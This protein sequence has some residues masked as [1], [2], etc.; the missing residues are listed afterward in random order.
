M[1]KLTQSLLQ[2]VKSDWL[3]LLMLRFVKQCTSYTLSDWMSSISSLNT[4]TL[5]SFQFVLEYRDMDDVMKTW[6]N[7]GYFIKQIE[8]SFCVCTVVGTFMMLFQPEKLHVHQN[9]WLYLMFSLSIFP[10]EMRVRDTQAIIYLLNIM[11]SSNQGNTSNNTELRGTSKFLWK[12]LTIVIKT[13]FWYDF[14]ITFFSYQKS[15]NCVNRNKVPIVGK[16]K[17]IWE[18]NSLKILK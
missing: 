18:K 6:K 2:V 9:T 3:I 15:I 7:L 1:Q 8:N 12:S 13:C 16:N 4:D 14:F 5:A 11:G 10:I 17:V